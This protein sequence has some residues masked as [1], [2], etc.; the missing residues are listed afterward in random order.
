MRSPR[1]LGSRCPVG[2]NLQRENR[3]GRE[4]KRFEGLIEFLSMLTFD[5][6][7]R[8]RIYQGHNLISKHV[9]ELHDAASEHERTVLG[10]CE[11]YIVSTN[12]PTLGER[13]TSGYCLSTSDILTYCQSES[14]CPK[15]NA[16][17][18][19]EETTEGHM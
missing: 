13:S 17:R 7:C 4:G 10:F 18:S 5:L 6:A 16:L 2:G 15:R 9:V 1:C 8:H 11:N 12:T 3:M 19:S 14:R